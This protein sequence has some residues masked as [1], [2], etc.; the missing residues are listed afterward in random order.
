MKKLISF[1]LGRYINLMAVFFP[2]YAGKFGFN[3]FCFPFRGKIKPFHQKFL[4]T[5]KH[6]IMDYDGIK[7]QVYKWNSGKKKL[8]FLHGWQSHSFRWKNYLENFPADEYTIYA[9]DAPGHGLSSGNFLT[10]PL[11]SN[12]IEKFIL[13]IDGVDTIISHS[14]GSF[15]A[16]YTLYRLP[17]LPVQ[18]LVLLA[19][20]GNASEFIEFYRNSLKLK[21]RSV[22]LILDYFENFIGESVDFF[23]ATKFGKNI[24]KPG[25]IIHDEEDEETSYH[26]AIA[27]HESWKKS[28]LV[29]TKGLSHNL[30]SPEIINKVSQFVQEAHPAEMTL[31]R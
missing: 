11:Y 18:K 29:I 27:I 31:T 30:K 23:S 28:Q 16:L 12:V 24:S 19:P 4:A 25:L 1:F 22:H 6:A 13:E 21:D 5:G 10:V 15:T 14:L 20:P 2:K 7:L 8:L 3:L 26:H 17:L 9:I